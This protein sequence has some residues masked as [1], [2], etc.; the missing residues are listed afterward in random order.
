MKYCMALA[1]AC[2]L[3][4]AQLAQLVGAAEKGPFESQ[5]RFQLDGHRAF[6]ILP[7]KLAAG[8]TP[9][10]LYA[11][12]LGNN[13]P[14]KAEKWMFDQFLDRGI[15]IAGI[16][17]G[18]SYGSPR[19]RNIYNRLH[20][21]LTTAD[22]E[23]PGIGKIRQFDRQACLLAR[24]RGGLMLYCWAEDNPG[25]VRCIVGIYPVCN[26]TSYPGLAR[27][28]GAYGLTESQL[29]ARLSEHNPV[30]RIAA[31]AKARVP[32]FHIHGDIDKTVPLDDNS[33]L[34]A[35]RYRLAGGKM[36]VKVAKGQGHNMWRGFFE[37]QR[38]VDFLVEHATARKSQAKSTLS[39]ERKI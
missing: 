36:E 6:V 11:P 17:V 18:E 25:K 22:F 3:L 13:L 26:L 29:A 15:A 9:W 20:D 8:P 4:S 28:S 37:H 35:Q 16:D 32:I 10:V 34:L 14:G 39:S 2:V 21:R 5:T 30:D 31:L 1:V 27:A 12:T 38:L 7:D 33:A 19:G 23:L 24:S